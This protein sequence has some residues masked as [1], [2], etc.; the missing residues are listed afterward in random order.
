[1]LSR[2]EQQLA[3]RVQLFNDR[4]A[5]MNALLAKKQ[6]RLEAQFQAMEQSLAM[7]QQ[8]QTAL[9][10]LASVNWSAGSSSSSSR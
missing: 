3:D 6:Q 5:D 4:I 1:L 8:Q 10:G 2:Q 9:S 7:L